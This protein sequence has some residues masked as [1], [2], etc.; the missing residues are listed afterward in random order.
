MQIHFFFPLQV[1]LQALAVNSAFTGLKLQLVGDPSW[2]TESWGALGCRKGLSVP[3]FFLLLEEKVTA[4]KQVIFMVSGPL[5]APPLGMFDPFFLPPGGE[6]QKTKVSLE[7]LFFLHF[8]LP[9]TKK[10]RVS[11]Q[12][13]W[14]WICFQIPWVSFDSHNRYQFSCSFVLR[15]TP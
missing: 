4:T 14:A 9:G 10:A 1:L 13:S 6:H 12:V 2:N 7:L 3:G 8:S 11:N 5:K 15:V